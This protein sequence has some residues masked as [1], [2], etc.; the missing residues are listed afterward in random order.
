MEVSNG[1]GKIP[2]ANSG[3]TN[4]VGT[5]TNPIVNGVVPQVNSLVGV[6]EDQAGNSLLNGGGLAAM[7]ANT[8]QRAQNG[9]VQGS[10]G[11][12]AMLDSYR[13]MWQPNGGNSY[14]IVGG[15]GNII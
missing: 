15:V 5:K 3:A 4:S 14:Q 1:V 13:N 6:Q 12:S 9:S 11:L 8:G 7:F 2:R 10:Q